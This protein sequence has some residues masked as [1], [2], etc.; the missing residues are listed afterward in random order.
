MTG[1][2]DDVWA[3]IV[4]VEGKCVDSTVTMHSNDDYR[5]E[6]N[7]WVEEKLSRISNINS[8]HLIKGPWVQT[9]SVGWNASQE[10]DSSWN[11][12]F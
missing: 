3:G 2:E 9:G 1:R 7:Q 8:D 5:G 6:Y 12:K 11:N 4:N 10:E